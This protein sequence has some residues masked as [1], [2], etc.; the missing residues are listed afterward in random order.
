LEELNK[1]K[2]ALEKEIKHT[3][4]QEEVIGKL[5]KLI[6]KQ[7]VLLTDKGVLSSYLEFEELRSESDAATYSFLDLERL[8]EEL[9]NPY[10]K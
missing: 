1:L 10:K 9:K 3:K 6:N 7:E 5:V 8:K 2:K 4:T